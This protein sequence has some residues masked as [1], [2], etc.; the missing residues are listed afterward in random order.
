MAT[1]EVSLR[2]VANRVNELR[3]HVDDRIDGLASQLVDLRSE[4]ADLRSDVAGLRGEWRLAKW[5]LAVFGAPVWAA[6]I[7]VIIRDISASA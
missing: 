2:D 4:V 1:Y 5:V 6:V 7:Y 3:A